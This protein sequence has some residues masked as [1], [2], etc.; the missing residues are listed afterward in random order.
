M[1]LTEIE[2]DDAFVQACAERLG[3]RLK[4][5]AL[6][7]QALCHRSWCA[8]H[9]VT[10]SNE[11]LEF[12]GDSVLGIVIT[13]FIF[14]EYPNFSE[15]ELAKLRQSVVSATTLAEVANELD[16]GSFI[17][18]GKGEDQAGGREKPS[19]LADAFEAVIGA[20]YVDSGMD[21]AS[22]FILK[23]FREV[24]TEGSLVPGGQDFKTRFQEYVARNL[25][26]VPRYTI[27]DSG[28]DHA[29]VF[30]ADVLVGDEKWGSGEGRSKRQA[31]QEA[32][33]SAWDRIA[34]ETEHA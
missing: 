28:P 21:A 14:E 10:E 33:R 4:N 12:L 26:S 6:L 31:E 25:G 32:A 27:S 7:R 34:G 8:E 30:A 15:G 18:L 1:T 20:I 13:K 2:I 23:L 3:V 19:I 11:R 5:P 22:D 24:V 16:L 17:L 29:K 9:P